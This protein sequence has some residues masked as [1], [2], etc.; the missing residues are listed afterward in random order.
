MRYDFSALQYLLYPYGDDSLIH[1]LEI[2]GIENSSL[3]VRE[4][5][6]KLEIEETVCK[7]IPANGKVVEHFVKYRPDVLVL[8]T[9]DLD[10]DY[11]IDLTDQL[12]KNLPA[13]P[14]LVNISQNRSY[15][16]D[17]TLARYK[18]IYYITNP[19]L[20]NS[21]VKNCR[22]FLLTKVISRENYCDKLLKC[23]ELTL[24]SMSCDPNAEAFR[25][26][27]E[28]VVTVLLNP[29]VRL[30]YQ[31]DI[32]QKLAFKYDL[33]IRI[34]ENRFKAAV[35]DALNRMPPKDYALAFGSTKPPDKINSVEFIQ[36]AAY[37]T[38][39]PCRKILRNLEDEPFFLPKYKEM[40]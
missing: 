3:L 30:N 10:D 21:Y 9:D 37:I 6:N 19:Y 4:L 22:Q 27:A 5:L 20:L 40:H 32:Y 31:R 7:L 12:E 16:K 28:A 29:Y 18:S 11:F 1:S 23:A 15:R 17:M 36:R 2:A 39:L 33:S 24:T 8:S 34:V 35:E 14:T 26:L 13:L 38:S 25:F